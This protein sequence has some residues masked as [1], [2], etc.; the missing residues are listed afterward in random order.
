VWYA[1][2]R[3]EA[4]GCNALTSSYH[5]RR[6]EYATAY[7]GPD[8]GAI[9]ADKLAALLASKAKLA[10]AVSSV[11]EG[12]G[13]LAQVASTCESS[14]GVS[15]AH[16]YRALHE[17]A[18]LLPS[19]GPDSLGYLAT[20]LDK[21]KYFLEA[22]LGL[23]K[24]ILAKASYSL[25]LTAKLDVVLQAL[26]A[27]EASYPDYS[28]GYGAAYPTYWNV[29]KTPAF[30][31]YGLQSP[32]F[33]GEW[34]YHDETDF[35]STWDTVYG[36]SAG[37]KA[38]NYATTGSGSYSSS[39]HTGYGSPYKFPTCSELLCKVSWLQG[40]LCHIET[41]LLGSVVEA[42]KVGSLLASKA[43]KCFPV[44]TTGYGY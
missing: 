29:Q 32:A 21:I 7:G 27:C 18:S 12:V 38:A 19:T 13:A 26:A 23:E 24:V 14:L 1:K 36:S 30:A 3:F 6:L 44:A 37:V 22:L 15:Y 25:T 39:S 5:D 43:A 33:A 4:A 16:A 9:C 8:L 2:E 11:V 28:S 42:V 40:E 35:Q 41:K 31:Y 34:Q 17:V 20:C 10:A